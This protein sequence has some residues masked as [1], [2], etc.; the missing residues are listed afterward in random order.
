MAAITPTGGAPPVRGTLPPAGPAAPAA[1]S[2]ALSI[3]QEAI[4]AAA[5]TASTPPPAPLTTQACGMASS[6]ASWIVWGAK[7]LH[8]GGAFATHWGVSLV[9]AAAGKAYNW[10][11]RLPLNAIADPEEIKNK[12]TERQERMKKALGDK[13]NHQLF[14]ELF[15]TLAIWTSD[16]ISHVCTYGDRM[17]ENICPP[18]L[19]QALFSNGQPTYACTCLKALV[20]E[21][22]N[23]EAFVAAVEANMVQLFCNFLTYLQSKGD[24]PQVRATAQAVHEFRTLKQIL[25]S[26]GG[27]QEK[28]TAESF[29]DISKFLLQICMPYMNED[30]VLPIWRLIDLSTILRFFPQVSLENAL[31]NS[32]LFAYKNLTS[33]YMRDQLANM[34]IHE[35]KD[36][37]LKLI[38]EGISGPPVKIDKVLDTEEQWCVNEIKLFIDRFV[39]PDLQ[40]KLFIYNNKE[41]IARSLL[42]MLKEKKPIQMMQDMIKPLL[43]NLYSDGTWTGDHFEIH[44]QGNFILGQADLER[45]HDRLRADTLQQRRQFLDDIGEAIGDRYFAKKHDGWAITNFFRYLASRCL[46]GVFNLAL[47]ATGYD[48]FVT[49]S[50][51]TVAHRI[52]HLKLHEAM[53][54]IYKLADER[55]KAF[56]ARHKAVPQ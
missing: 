51:D 53:F 44:G 9:S 29:N 28:L 38:R 49:T 21:P 25:P 32:L 11:T 50:L 42:R 46:K 56:I 40:K 54:P 24:N 26:G 43:Q 47:W 4:A 16:Y 35:S 12:L 52:E 3:A 5:A 18:L 22:K 17:N 20:Q 23:H 45:R 27:D 55:T 34:L 30:I 33:S 8:T 37:I 1:P 15:H 7:G 14:T 36:A 41:R 48:K 31:S 10:V 13:C 19:L 2:A 39:P 6:A